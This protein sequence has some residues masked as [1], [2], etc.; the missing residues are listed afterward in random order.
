MTDSDYE[1]VEAFLG[2][3][4]K[5]ELSPADM[6]AGLCAWGKSCGDDTA[7]LTIWDQL[8]SVDFSQDYAAIDQWTTQ[9]LSKLA[10][11]EKLDI[12][13]IRLAE[14]P[15]AFGV[16]AL[17]LSKGQGAVAAFVKKHAKH[18]GWDDYVDWEGEEELVYKTLQEMPGKL[19]HDI[20][21]MIYSAYDNVWLD[22]EAAWAIWGAFTRHAV[23]KT[24]RSGKIDIAAT[25]GSRTHVP[26]CIGSEDE[27]GYM[28]ILT[29]QGWKPDHH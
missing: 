25:L 29:S 6:I 23:A 27:E 4:V 1:R 22:A 26:I 28:G 16:Y 12:L 10:N 14:E 17:P 2:K 20:Y 11:N 24:L 18:D 3:C 8:P 7:T 21:T 15:E 5:E 9:A 13:D 19:W